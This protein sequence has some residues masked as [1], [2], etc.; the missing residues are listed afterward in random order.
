MGWRVNRTLSGG[1]DLLPQSGIW[2]K[3]PS[4]MTG[5]EL[6]NRIRYHRV[7]GDFPAFADFSCLAEFNFAAALSRVVGDSAAAN[8]NLAPSETA[9]AGLRAKRYLMPFAVRCGP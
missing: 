5:T 2:R 7:T 4:G 6:I 1:L 9:G 8:D 3:R